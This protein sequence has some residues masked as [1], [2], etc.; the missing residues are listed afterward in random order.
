MELI[1]SSRIIPMDAGVDAKAVYDSITAVHL[2]TPD[3]NHLLLH[4]RAMREFLEAGHVDRLYWFGTND[5]LPDGLTKGSVEREALIKCCHEGVWQIRNEQ[6]EMWS[7]DQSRHD[8][9]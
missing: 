7:F 8:D 6:P 1:D 4:A 2:K 5:M 9:E 3:D